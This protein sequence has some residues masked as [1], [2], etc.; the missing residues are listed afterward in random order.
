VAILAPVVLEPG[1]A[2]IVVVAP[3]AW[4][5]LEAVAQAEAPPKA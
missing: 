5:P 4:P 3:V 2:R 1:E